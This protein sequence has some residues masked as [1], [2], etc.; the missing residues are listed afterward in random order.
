MLNSECDQHKLCIVNLLDRLWCDIK[1]HRSQTVSAKYCQLEWLSSIYSLV[2]ISWRS[3]RITVDWC[4]HVTGTHSTA[5]VT[6]NQ[7]QYQQVTI[8]SWP[9]ITGHLVAVRHNDTWVEDWVT[10][11]LRL[12]WYLRCATVCSIGWRVTW[13]WPVSHWRLQMHFSKIKVL[14]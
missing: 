5:A 7:L 1:C 8:T 6:T 12:T 13:H 9:V 4:D 10:L 11:V 2:H 3:H 14:K